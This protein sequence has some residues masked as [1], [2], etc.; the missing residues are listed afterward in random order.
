MYI[1][2]GSVFNLRIQNHE[3]KKEYYNYFTTPFVFS[4]LL[5]LKGF[6]LKGVY[7]Q[8]WDDLSKVESYFCTYSSPK[9][10]LF[11]EFLLKNKYVTKFFPTTIHL[12][13]STKKKGFLKS[14]GIKITTDPM[15]PI[16]KI[17][18]K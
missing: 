3:E 15:I 11:E 9:T 2:K 13:D 12:E 17:D 1:E 5:A 16:Q 4:D 6:E 14:K 8:F 10:E 7:N 18:L